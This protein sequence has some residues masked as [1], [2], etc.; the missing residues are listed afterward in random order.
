MKSSR[1]RLERFRN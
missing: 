1:N